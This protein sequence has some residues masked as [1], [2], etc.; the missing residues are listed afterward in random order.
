MQIL[1]TLLIGY[2]LLALFVMLVQRK[3]IYYPS[4]Y[5]SE[6]AVRLAAQEGFQEW[7]DKAGERI[8]WL[9]PAS[10]PTNGAVLVV[11]GNA[12]CAFNRG[13]LAQPIRTAAN[14][15]VFVLEYPG[16]GCR[17]GSPSQHA[18]LKA[19]DEAFAGLSDRNPLYIV[20]ESLGA[21]AAAH[22]AG[23]QPAKVAGLALFAPYDSLASVGQSQMPFLPVNLLLRD[24]FHPA[25]SLK[26]YR[27]S[28]KV[29]LAEA[30]TIVPAKFGQ[31]L[32]DGYHGPKSVEVVRGAGHNDIAEQSPEWWKELFSFWERNSK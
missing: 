29:V 15:D 17:A 6:E 28:V 12:G 16:Y 20:S 21:G 30:D 23:K 22:L 25:G 1:L 2:V 7:R 19:A 8:G 3:L 32:Y 5:S 9:L 14:V 11:H 10:R 24:R 27:G 26:N 31:R 13:Y 18:I 4:K